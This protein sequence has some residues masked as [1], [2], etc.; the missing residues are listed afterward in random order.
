MF[1]VHQQHNGVKES[2]SP[3]KY[4]P[5]DK[6]RD[7]TSKL[8]EAILCRKKPMPNK[9]HNATLEQ[10]KNWLCHSTKSTKDTSINRIFG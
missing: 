1:I 4:Q 7:K 10:I 8:L 3:K 6:H 2:I 9:L 5:L